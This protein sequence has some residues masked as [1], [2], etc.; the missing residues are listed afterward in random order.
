VTTHKR[1]HDANLSQSSNH[2]AFC[3]GLAFSF[4]NLARRTEPPRLTP[5]QQ[6]AIERALTRVV[7]D[8]LYVASLKSPADYLEAARL[9]WQ[10]GRSL[11]AVHPRHLI[12]TV[13]NSFALRG[14]A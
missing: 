6:A 1:V 14:R 12:R 10:A 4:L 9:A 8:N 13:L 3:K 2:L 11:Q 7:G 5:P